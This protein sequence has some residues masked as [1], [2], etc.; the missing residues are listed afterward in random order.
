MQLPAALVTPA[1][2]NFLDR[3]ESAPITAPAAKHVLALLD[4]MSKKP[5][6]TM[7]AMMDRLGDEIMS[8]LGQTKLRHKLS[9]SQGPSQV[10]SAW[11]ASGYSYAAGIM[12]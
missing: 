11:S 8:Y 6:Q 1:F 5:S 2:G 12:Q 9:L 7:P 4:I 10:G 3:R